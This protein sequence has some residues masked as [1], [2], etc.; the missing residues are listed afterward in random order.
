MMIWIRRA[1]IVLVSLLV[2][3]AIAVAGLVWNGERMR[4]RIVRL[5][6]LQS[7]AFRRHN[8]ANAPPVCVA[9]FSVP[10]R[11]RRGPRLRR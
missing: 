3:A 4:A 6:A 5:P 7:T 2:L 10:R 11:R 8:G 9:R 1:M